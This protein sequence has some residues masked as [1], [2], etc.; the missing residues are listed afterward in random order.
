MS[1]YGVGW[2]GAGGATAAWLAVG[3]AGPSVTFGAAASEAAADTDADAGANWFAM[4][5]GAAVDIRS[6]ICAKT[7]FSPGRA[8]GRWPL[9]EA[10]FGEE[11]DGADTGEAPDMP[12]APDAAEP[13]DRAEAAEVLEAADCVDPADAPEAADE[14]LGAD[15]PLGAEAAVG[16][17]HPLAL[18]I[19]AG[20]DGPAAAV[21]R[22]AACGASGTGAGALTGAG[23][24]T[25]AG[26]AGQPPSAGCCRLVS[27]FGPDSPAVTEAS[28]TVRICRSMP[29]TCCTACRR[30]SAWSPLLKLAAEPWVLN[31]RVNALPSMLNGE[32][33]E[34]TFIHVTR[35]MPLS[36]FRISG[37]A[38][39]IISI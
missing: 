12:L 30:L 5:L 39:R 6:A 3:P 31:P 7:G 26:L 33:F 25:V 24:P 11:A 34:F 13:A 20:A 1:S 15:I 16:P 22:G 32:A 29:S 8:G 4:V 19:P 23:A 37:Q 14:A 38:R 9:P 10:L 27:T 18:A 35:R 28:S 17:D 21:G 2:V 36:V